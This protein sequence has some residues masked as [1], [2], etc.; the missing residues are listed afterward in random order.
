MGFKQHISRTWQMIEQQVNDVPFRPDNEADR[1]KSVNGRFPFG[2]ARFTKRRMRNKFL[3]RRS[4]LFHIFDSQAKRREYG[5]SAFIEMQFCKLPVGTERK[6]I[7]ATNRIQNWQLDSLYIEVDDVDTFYQEYSRIFTCGTY[8][9]LKN[10]VVD[11]FGVNYYAPESIDPMIEKIHKE[12][13]M[14]YEPLT[15]WLN[16]A[17]EYN[18]FYILGI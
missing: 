7:V 2:V 10:G 15:D 12:K 4:M 3:A 14:D 16:H 5:G 6:R 9:N 13:P 18:G 1:L 8:Q 17:K 11:I